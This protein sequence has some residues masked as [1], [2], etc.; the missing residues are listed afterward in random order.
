MLGR[1]LK[2]VFGRPTAERPPAAVAANRRVYAIGDIH[3]R[4]D[5]LDVMHRK[6]RDDASML[7][8]EYDKVVVYLGDYVDRGYERRPRPSDAATENGFIVAV[9]RPASSLPPSRSRLRWA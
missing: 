7:P 3:G 4:A 1:L 2:S 8:A 6:I 5:L 9:A